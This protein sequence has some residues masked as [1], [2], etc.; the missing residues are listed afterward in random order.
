MRIIKQLAVGLV[1]A[2]LS[3]LALALPTISFNPTPAFGGIGGSIFVD[4]VWNGDGA[5]YIGDFDVDI[6]YDGSIVSLAGADVD[7]QFGVDTFGCGYDGFFCDY[8]DSPGLVNIFE[9]S[10]DSVADLT[11]NQDGLGNSFVLAT[12]EFIGLTDGITTLALSENAV[13][14]AYGLPFEHVLTDG[15]ICVGTGS[16]N[17]PIDNVPEPAAFYLLAMGLVTT[18]LARR[19]LRV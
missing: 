12:L 6:A 9:V 2:G 16:E 7:P 17:C 1:L 13:G 14:N 19:K 11:A 3:N 10:F 5:N 15:L 18:L 4:L 8:S